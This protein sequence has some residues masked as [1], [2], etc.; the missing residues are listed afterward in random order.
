MTELLVLAAFA[1]SL[2]LC[3]GLNLSVLI[4]LVFGFFLFFGY[5]L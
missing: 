1:A 3:V 5:G 2:F 4:A